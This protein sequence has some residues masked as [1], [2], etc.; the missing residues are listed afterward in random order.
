MPEA[1][2][3]SFRILIWI[4]YRKINCVDN[5]NRQQRTTRS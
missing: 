5:G 1:S 4:N 2:L 3:K